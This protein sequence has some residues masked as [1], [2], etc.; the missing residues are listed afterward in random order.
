MWSRLLPVTS[1]SLPS[2]DAL[3][4]V[5]CILLGLLLIVR[6]QTRKPRVTALYVYPIKSCA[7]TFM[8]SARVT[9]R[10]FEG[11]RMFQATSE[12]FVCTPRDTDKCRLFHVQPKLEDGG[13][14]LTLEAPGVEP[15]KIELKRASTKPRSCG[16]N[17]E[18]DQRVFSVEHSLRA[19]YAE[20]HNLDD[21]G[22]EAATWLAHATGIN[23]VRLTGAPAS[24]ARTM[25]LNPAQQE[26]FPTA[27]PAPVNLADEA[28]FLLCAVESLH[29]LNRRM[30]ARGKAPVEMR[31]FR[32][33]IVIAGLQPWE[34]DS[35]KQVRIGG[36][37]FRAWQRCGRCRMTTIDRETLAYGPEPLATLSTFRE[38]A[39][40][41]RNFGIHLIPVEGVPEGALI[42]AGSAVKIVEYDEA[43]REEWLQLFGGK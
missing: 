20:K 23:G 22:D 32:P 2:V 29:D 15:L 3:A 16:I 4:A 5:L 13:S 40:G 10:G 30:R 26:P 28:P 19:Q 1:G 21:Y 34:E 38:R 6:R 24:F 9:A 41:Q 42:S 17:S 11:D 33:N 12:G 27:K 43:R 35:I 39:N 7:E 31:R 8:N 25:V 14:S 18:T 36:V 37:L